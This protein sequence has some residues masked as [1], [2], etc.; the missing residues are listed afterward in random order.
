[1]TVISEDQIIASS[2]RNR[3]TARAGDD[4]IVAGT[5]GN[6]VRSTQSRIGRRDFQQQ[7]SCTVCGLTMVTNH[8]VVTVARADCISAQAAQDAIVAFIAVDLIHITVFRT[9]SADQ[10]HVSSISQ[11]QCPSRLLDHTVVPED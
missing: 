1:M 7:A 9:I 2:G 10:G 5:A 8:D 4:Q 6:V 3:V 11:P